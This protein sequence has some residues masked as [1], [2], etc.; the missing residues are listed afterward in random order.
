M[1]EVELGYII[2]QLKPLDFAELAGVTRA[3]VTG[4][5]DGLEREGLVKRSPHPVDR[6]MIMIHLTAKG[7]QLLSQMLPDHFCRTAGLMANL[8]AP[9]KQRLIEL[10]AKVQAGTPTMC[11][12]G[13]SDGHGG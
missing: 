1:S 10:L 2:S 8:T 9:E 6:R 3:T 11:K 5:L 12:T 4:L 7:R 13:K